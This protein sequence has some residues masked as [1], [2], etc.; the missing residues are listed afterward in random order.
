MKITK[1]FWNV[2]IRWLIVFTIMSACVEQINFDSPP[3]QSMIVVEGFISDSTGPYTVKIS[4]ALDLD[5][6]SSRRQPV[7]NATITLFD[8]EGNEEDLAE[9]DPG[10]YMTG[11]VIHGQVGHAY[12]IH[13]ET[14]DGKIFESAPDK[15]KPG[16][17]IESIRYEFEE[18]TEDKGYGELDADVFKVY[19]DA[20]TG[21]AGENF[22][23]WRFKGT[24]KVF[25][26]PE[27]HVTFLQVSSYLTPVPCSGYIVV[28]ALGGGKLEKIGECTC[29]TCWVNQFEEIPQLSDEQL[30][31][32][33]QF[34][35]VEVAKI[36]INSSTFYDKYLVE[37]EQMSLSRT[38]FDYF[39]LIRAQKQGASSLF[40]PPSG[41][42]RGNVSPLNSND[43]VVG[44]FWATSVKRKSIFIP[45]GVVPYVLPPAVFVPDACTNYFPHSTTIQPASWQ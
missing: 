32:G 20:K 31:S 41:E 37:V 2:K 4:R 17:E 13:L 8:D 30:I 44:L 39:R 35:N 21:S 25:T 19:V 27:L 45:R 15:I 9:T 18:A 33:N 10:V 24:Y 43:L 28:A 7:T 6:D 26:N 14:S 3:A 5:A 42:I 29:C 23:R 12:H 40:Q 34:N 1:H 36:P 38:A 16:G 22:V 11:G